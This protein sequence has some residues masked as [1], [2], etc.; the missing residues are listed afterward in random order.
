MAFKWNFLER[1]N[2]TTAGAQKSKMAL[3]LLASLLSVEA[4]LYC[5]SLLT[6]GLTDSDSM[7]LVKDQMAA[8]KGQVNISEE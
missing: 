6:G 4:A 7:K 1:R 8:D 3:V 5:D 2:A